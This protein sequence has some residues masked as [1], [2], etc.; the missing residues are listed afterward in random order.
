MSYGDTKIV[1][2]SITYDN[3]SNNILVG[4]RKHD[5]TED[6]Q[7]AEVELNNADRRFTSLN[8]RGLTA[9]ISYDRGSGYVATPTL[10]V[11][12]QDDITAGGQYHTVLSLIGV[13]DLLKEDKASKEY[14]HARTDA[15]TVQDLITEVLSGTAVATT[16]TAEQLTM[17]SYYNL[18]GGDKIAVGQ[19]KLIKDKTVSTISF[20]LKKV[21]S[22]TGDITFYMRPAAIEGV[23]GWS[24]TESKVLGDA[25]TLSTSVAW[26]TVT[27][28]TSK[29]VDDQVVLYCEYQ[30]GDSSNYV[31]IGYSSSGVAEG[32]YLGVLYATG[33]W[34]YYDDLDC[35]YKY[36]YSVA[37]VDC[38]TQ[39]TAITPDFTGSATDALIDVYTPGD[40]FKIAE[41]ESRADVIDKLLEWTSSYK[42]I[43]SDGVM[44]FFVIPTSGNSYTSAKGDFY[45]H[46]NR[47]GLVV[48]NKIVVKSYDYE[49]DGYTGSAT[50]AASYALLP[51]TGSPV[52]AYVSGTTQANALAAAIIGRL[53]VNS[54]SGSATV[55]PANYEQIWNYV[56]VTNTWNGSTTTGN[57]A[58]LSIVSMGGRF[59]EFYSFGKQA[60]R[61]ISGLVPRRE[62]KLEPVFGDDT[63]LKWGMIKGIFEAINDDSDDQWKVFNII[64][65]ILEHMGVKVDAI[66]N[67]LSNNITKYLDGQVEGLS[68]FL[69]GVMQKLQV[70]EQLRIPV[71]P[72]E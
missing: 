37:G 8:L 54:Q 26:K 27:L 6:S 5:F 16:V 70:T 28:D 4:V 72:K 2:N 41:G 32:E 42:R 43:E 46:V 36:G 23:G 60:R 66:D 57:I 68:V 49:G 29:Y 30:G 52:R 17:G 13:P 48:P 47:K 40:A 25:S 19:S 3:N 1:I 58:Y 64:E 69:S 53:E 55:Y 31:A 14:L 61:G 50:S 21:G 59:E 35:G 12:T 24:W 63:V 62:V 71:F 34:Q 11:V 44:Y 56:T 7:T 65:G 39:R 18:Y 38:F 67:D 33:D 9:V 15:K 22:P 51:I 45:S 10:T 20:S